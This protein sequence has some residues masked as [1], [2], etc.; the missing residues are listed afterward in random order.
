MISAISQAGSALRESHER[1]EASADRIS[2]A[3]TSPRESESS[4]R[5]IEE[6]SEPNDTQDSTSMPAES[7]EASA[8][9]ASEE[10]DLARELAEQIQAQ[11]ASDANVAMIHSMDDTVG[12]L[13]DAFA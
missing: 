11:S 9:A 3:F 8:G 1:I 12:R 5:P 2:S 10:V 4:V 7:D 13:L 6:T